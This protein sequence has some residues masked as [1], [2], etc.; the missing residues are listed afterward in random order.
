M[1]GWF[2]KVHEKTNEQVTPQVLC[3]HLNWTIHGHN[4]IGYATCL[5]CNKPI[6]LDYAFN[7]LHEKM[8]ATITTAEKEIVALRN[9]RSNV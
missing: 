8:E 4:T 1:F 7:K 3:E 6:C 9:E 5:D 2:I